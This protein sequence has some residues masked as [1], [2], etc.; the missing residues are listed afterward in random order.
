MDLTDDGPAVKPPLPRLP[1]DDVAKEPPV[2]AGLCMFEI[3]HL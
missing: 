3:I 2:Q 1:Q